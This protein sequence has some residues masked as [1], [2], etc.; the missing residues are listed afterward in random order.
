MRTLQIRSFPD[1]LYKQLK[2]IAKQ[3]RRSMSQQAAILIERALISS[4]V[5]GRERRKQIIKYLEQNPFSLNAK[6]LPSSDV[7]V[8]EDRDR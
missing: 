8:R 6:H 2:S 3:E 1:N 4:H 5:D 7:L